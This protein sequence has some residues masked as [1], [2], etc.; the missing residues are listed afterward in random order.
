M[1]PLDAPMINGMKCLVD[2]TPESENISHFIV[3]LSK[4]L[5]F[6]SDPN[7]PTNINL[8][9]TAVGE[10][11]PTLIKRDEMEVTKG[12]CVPGNAGQYINVIETAYKKS[13]MQS[14][15]KFFRPVEE[16]DNILGSL[17]ERVSPGPWQKT[18]FIITQALL[19]TDQSWK[20]DDLSNALDQRMQQISQANSHPML[21]D[22]PPI[23]ESLYL[24][25]SHSEI[26]RQALEKSAQ[27][28]AML[29]LFHWVK[30]NEIESASVCALAIYSSNQNLNHPDNNGYMAQTP[31]FRIQ[32]G[33]RNLNEFSQNPSSNNPK[34]FKALSDKCLNWLPFNEWRKVALVQPARKTI[35]SEM[36]RDVIQKGGTAQIPTSELVEN[37]EFWQELLGD[38][39]LQTALLQKAERGDLSE[40]LKTIPFKISTAWLDL[41]ALRQN[42]DG[43]YEK[44][45]TAGIKDCTLDQWKDALRME[46]PLTEI[47]FFLADLGVDMGK[48]FLDAL[49]THAQA[50]LSQSDTGRLASQWPE[51]LELLSDSSKCTFRQTLWNLFW[52]NKGSISGL[53]PYYGAS[54]SEAVLE[55]RPEEADARLKQII[56]TKGEAELKWLGDVLAKWKPMKQGAIATRSYLARAVEEELAG[57]LLD[58]QRAA[59]RQLLNVLQ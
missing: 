42:R 37:I 13:Q 4:S 33:R 23:L 40:F 46:T 55:H 39:V 5:I 22:L 54:L 16:T 34:L 44:K 19:A 35:V 28:G 53:L 21:V 20:W 25:S 27:S 58:E 18:D 51:L 43:E 45:I 3:S 52:Q 59:F 30:D 41:I 32:Q 31:A 10:I 56:E 12:F 2:M 50:R 17:Q 14:I 15:L 48:V 6:L 47:A 29:G 49:T 36:L 38:E 8:W 1:E 24:L 7:A 9:L 26:S 57:E 11:L